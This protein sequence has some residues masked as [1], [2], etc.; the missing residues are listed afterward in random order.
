MAL[1]QLVST[2][3]MIVKS[4]TRDIDFLSIL[5]DIF[6]EE[7]GTVG[8]NSLSDVCLS[9]SSVFLVVVPDLT[10]YNWPG[11]YIFWK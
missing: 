2:I 7:I 8:I 5:V 1:S 11:A 4:T 6:V 10:M 3:K 9:L